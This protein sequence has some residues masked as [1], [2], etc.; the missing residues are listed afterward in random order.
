MNTA[1]CLNFHG[2]G[3]PER[4][5]EDDEVP[6]WVSVP[7]FERVLDHVAHAPS[8]TEYFITFDDG[9]RSDISIALPALLDRGLTARFFVLTGRLDQPG[10]L[11]SQD[12]R[13]LI[14]A[15]MKI[16]SHGI[17]HVAWPSLS[18]A[19]LNKELVASRTQLETICG[20][21]ITEAGIP[22]GRYDRRVIAALKSAGYQ[23]IWTS[24]GGHMGSDGFIKARTSLR[25]NMSAS[26]LSDALNAVMP[27][28]KK[29]R[30]SIGM[31]RKRLFR[32]D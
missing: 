8:T 20:Q 32:T 1:I 7:Q 26:E 3:T 2:I 21:P 10:S 24:D 19:E 9:N 14:D 29:L 28:A 15:G 6:Y 17:D 12:L 11:G 22:F 27:L 18:D 30:R 25:G 23:T 13:K 31:A 16:G 4:M 5:L